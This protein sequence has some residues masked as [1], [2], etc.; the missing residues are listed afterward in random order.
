MR[1]LLR[2]YKPFTRAGVL[3]AAQYRANFICFIAGDI[4]RCFINYFLWHTV[5]NSGGAETF[6][7]FSEID[8]VSYI[9]I[10]FLTATIA[11]S[12][13]AF[14]VGEEI[15]D[16]NISMRLIK[17]IRFDLSFLFQ[18]LGERTLALSIAFVPLVAGVE[19]FRYFM[20][21]TVMFNPLSFLLYLVSLTLAYLITFYFNVCYGYS[22]FVLK[23]LWG[24]NLTKEC[25]VSFLSGAVIPLAF[26]PAWLGG[27][28]NLLPFAALS[29]TPVMI[30]IGKLDAQ[31]II[32]SLALQ[33]FWLAFFYALQQLIWKA[34]VKRLSVQGG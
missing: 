25:I 28:L 20:T 15:R 31:G 24:S 14:A 11:Y 19:L 10:S 23:N 32:I 2:I 5:F 30:Y 4:L 21:G 18:E 16:G 8:M 27:V 34:C 22:A 26:M 6:M 33:V 13:G 12:D 9:F 7:G 3:M 17:P 1:K 29:Y